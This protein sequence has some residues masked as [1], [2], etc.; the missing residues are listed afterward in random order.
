MPMQQAL[1]DICHRLLA[2]WRY[3]TGAALTAFGLQLLL[4]LARIAAR[5]RR[6]LRAGLLILTAIAVM[7]LAVPALMISDLYPTSPPIAGWDL[8]SK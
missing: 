7:S 8:T 5:A 2:M 1:L 4:A 6:L 3:P